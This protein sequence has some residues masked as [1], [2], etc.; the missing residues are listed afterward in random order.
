MKT[1]PLEELDRRIADTLKEQSGDEA[2]LLTENSVASGLLLRVPKEL[3]NSKFD[4]AVCVD[5]PEGPV[6]V[7]VE[8]KPMTSSHRTA[9]AESARPQFG[10]C[11]GMLKVVAEDDEHLKDF[12]EYMR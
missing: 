2:V 11:R 9:V 5:G 10:S 1:I 7:L 4:V 3:I 8:V 12:D 6:L